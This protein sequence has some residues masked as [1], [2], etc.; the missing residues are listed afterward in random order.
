M[1]KLVSFI[2]V[3]VPCWGHFCHEGKTM[4]RAGQGMSRCSDTYLS[5][6][7]V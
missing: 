2:L 3:Q 4:Q 7:W 6:I 5:S 1:T